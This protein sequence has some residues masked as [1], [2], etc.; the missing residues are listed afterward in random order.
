[1][2]S[3]SPFRP[4]AS[5]AGVFATIPLAARAVLVTG[6]ADFDSGKIIAARLAEKGIHRSDR[7]VMVW[8]Q[9]VRSW[10]GFP[11]HYP[12][13]GSTAYRRLVEE[14]MTRHG[15][16]SPAQILSGW[17]PDSPPAWTISP[18]TPSA[19]FRTRSLLSA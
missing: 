3:S 10:L 14:C 7:T 17:Q 11:D 9:A 4:V 5:F 1:M 8:L 12:C 15:H 18:P 13:A 19:S 6:I 2:K 16:P